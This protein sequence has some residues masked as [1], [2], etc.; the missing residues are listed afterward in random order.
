MSMLGPKMGTWWVESKADHRWNKSGRG[1][2]LVTCGGPSE[3]NDW[4]E[5]CTK[6]FGK[7]PED[8]YQGFF[9]D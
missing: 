9:K 8:L 2:G 6:E 4:V 7:P 1:Y 5:R 3:I